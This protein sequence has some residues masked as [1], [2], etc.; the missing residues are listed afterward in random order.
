MANNLTAKEKSVLKKII[1]EYRLVLQAHDGGVEVVSADAGVI[2]LRQVG[3]CKGC[4]M[5]ALTFGLGI[6]QDI[7]RK[8]RRIKAVKY[9]D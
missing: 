1:A 2:T 5:S 9:V 6:E 3:R 7:K 4:P 8:I